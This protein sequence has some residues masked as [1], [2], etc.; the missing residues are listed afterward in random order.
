MVII[1]IA[2]FL[3]LAFLPRIAETFGKSADKTQEEIL[4]EKEEEQKRQEKGAGCNTIDFIFGEGSCKNIF[5]GGETQ[6]DKDIDIIDDSA[7]KE[8]ERKTTFR[9]E[10]TPKKTIDTSQVNTQTEIKIKNNEQQL[11]R[12]RRFG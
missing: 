6:E 12:T 2:I 3:L 5:G 10:D 7:T 1:I 8:G 4:I 11:K 9:G